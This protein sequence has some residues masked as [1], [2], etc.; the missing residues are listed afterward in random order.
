MLLVGIKLAPE[1]ILYAK[2][3]KCA[4]TQCKTDKFSCVSAEINCFQ[5]S[6][7]AKNV[8]IKVIC[9]GMTMK[10]KRKIMMMTRVALKTNDLL[11]IPICCID[12]SMTN[13][14]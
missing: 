12:I 9:S 1:K 7:V 6:V 3:C 14:L 8:I 11:D 5:N 2:R 13:I 4:S 10:L